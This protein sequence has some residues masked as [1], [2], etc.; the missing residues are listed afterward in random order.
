MSPA[1]KP[2]SSP[3]I[4]ATASE[5]ARP[6]TADDDGQ[7]HRLQPVALQ[8]LHELRPDRVADAKQEQQEQEGLGH[9]RNGHMRELPDQEAGKKR[10]RDRA[11]AERPDLEAADPVARAITRNSASSG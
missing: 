11:E 8:R 7:Q 5:A 4:F 9:A 10:A 2:G 3:R 6:V 1:A